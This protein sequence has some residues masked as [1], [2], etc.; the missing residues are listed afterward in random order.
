MDVLE[1]DLVWEIFFVGR[2][3]P[4]A[5]K[6]WVQLEFDLDRTHFF[7]IQ[8]PKILLAFSVELV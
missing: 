8:N 4:I 7:T 5:K 1:S 6:G 3:I 2:K